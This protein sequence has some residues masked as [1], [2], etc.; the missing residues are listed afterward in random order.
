MRRRRGALR[1]RPLFSRTR[2]ASGCVAL[3]IAVIGSGLF[4]RCM[5][6]PLTAM[7]VDKLLHYVTP[8]LYLGWWLAGARHGGLRRKLI[9]CAELLFPA[10][11]RLDA[12][13][14]R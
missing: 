6:W 7:V 3:C 12:A 1:H 8:V 13:A 10:N 11:S 14:R 5:T 4:P 2:P 9:P